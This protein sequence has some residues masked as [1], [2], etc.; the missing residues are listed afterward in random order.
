MNGYELTK[1][2]RAQ[3]DR[4]HSFIRFWRKE[5]DFLDYDLLDRFLGNLRDD[6]VV[7]GFELLNTDAMW[8]EVRHVAGSVVTR[9]VRDGQDVLLWTDTEGRVTKE[10]PFNEESLITIFDAETDDNYVD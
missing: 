10:L 4:S 2:I 6:Q 9:T 3:R 8:N 5:E 1:A 7:D